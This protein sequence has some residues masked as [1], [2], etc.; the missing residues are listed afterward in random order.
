MCLA[1]APDQKGS[2]MTSDEDP[3]VDRLPRIQ[4]EEDDG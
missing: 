3:G 4:E 1:R 2:A